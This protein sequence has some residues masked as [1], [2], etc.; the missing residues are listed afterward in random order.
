MFALDRMRENDNRSHSIAAKAIVRQN[1][2]TIRSTAVFQQ[3]YDLAFV[4]IHL[5][6]E[7][8]LC[9]VFT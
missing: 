3:L 9:L 2:A 5:F 7:L 1:T 4:L 8:R 6:S